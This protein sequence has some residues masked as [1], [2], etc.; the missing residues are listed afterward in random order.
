[1]PARTGRVFVQG[2]MMDRPLLT[3]EILKH[4]LRNY[5]TTEIVTRTVEGPIHRYT[6]ADAGQRIAKLANALTRLGVKKGDRVGVIGWNTYRQFE[7][8]YAVGGLGAVLHTVNPRLGPENA[9]FVIKHAE[10]DWLFYDTTF[11]P[12]VDAIAKGLPNLKG[13]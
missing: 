10:D 5:R 3:T 9:A 2:L 4:A 12:L 1:M 11:A 8:Y 6:I 7:M 13:R